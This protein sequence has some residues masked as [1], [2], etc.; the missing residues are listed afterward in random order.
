M[1]NCLKAN[2]QSKIHSK[3]NS[4]KNLH[5]FRVNLDPNIVSNQKKDFFFEK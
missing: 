3:Q 4:L 5:A 1:K 2:V